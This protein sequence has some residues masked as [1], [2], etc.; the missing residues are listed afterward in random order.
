MLEAQNGMMQHLARR[1]VTVC[2][3]VFATWH[4]ELI[5]ET[6]NGG[7]R[8]F[9]RLVSFLEGTVMGDVARHSEELLYDLGQT[10]GQIDVALL[11]FDHPALHYEFHWDLAR[12]LPVIEEHIEKVPDGEV[13][14]LVKQLVAQFE[15]SMTPLLPTLRQSVIH[16]DANDYNLILASSDNLY[17]HQ[18]RISGVIDF[19]DSI[20]SHTV[21]ELAIAI[22][23]AILDKA[24]PLAA[25]AHIVRGYHSSNTQ[26]ARCPLTDNE[27]AVLWGLVQMR[28]CVSVC[29][30]AH[31]QSLRPDD[32]YLGISQQPIRNTLPKIA[33]VHLRLAEAV[34][35]EACGLP[36]L[37][38]LRQE[39]SH[40]GV[41]HCQ[42]GDIRAHFACRSAP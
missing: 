12:A 19:G 32:E 37:A 30:A 6:T 41:A 27:F 25:A 34:F 5:A 15:Q 20:Y 26:R 2:P 7:K 4:G 17:E 18:Q 9:V 28:L 35:R 38:P 39:Q 14:R 36:R 31:Q 3:Q 13:K 22:A 11:D 10:M 21:N 23:Y 16:N 40:S 29:M 42:S 8:H 1:G 24:D 33:Q